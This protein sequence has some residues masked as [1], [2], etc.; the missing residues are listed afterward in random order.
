MIKNNIIIRNLGVTPYNSTFDA[1]VNFTSSRTDETT[2]EIW[3]TEHL[4]VFTQGKTGKAEHLVEDNGSIPIIQSNRGGQITYHGPGQQIMYVLI[5]LRRRKVAIKD[6]VASLERCVI[7]CLAT[8]QIRAEK[9]PT[10][11]GVYISGSG[12]KICSLGLHI[13][14]G[15]T[16]HGL[17]FNLD[18]DLTPFRFINPCGF[19][20][21][22]MAKLSQFTT[23]FDKQQIRQ[24]MAS[25][26]ANSLGYEKIDC[27]KTE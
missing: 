10:A 1:M 22:K 9:K 13:T 25:V 23:Q 19:R 3:F 27:V 11:P 14:R 26:F 2:D 21:L 24:L 20:E 15:C 17:A 18:M 5:D 6:V 8:F 4:P 16:L 12:E 7:D